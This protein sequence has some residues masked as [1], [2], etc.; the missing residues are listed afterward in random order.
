M[1]ESLQIIMKTFHT[2]YHPQSIGKVERLNGILML[3]IQNMM[4]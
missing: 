2:P 4:A 3:K 1:G